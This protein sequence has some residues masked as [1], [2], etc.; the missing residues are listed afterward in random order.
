MNQPIYLTDAYARD[1]AA[2]VIAITDEGGIV[3]DLSLI[4]I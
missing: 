1:S 2:K 4:H 3:L